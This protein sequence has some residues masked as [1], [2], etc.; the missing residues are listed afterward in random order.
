MTPIYFNGVLTYARQYDEVL[1]WAEVPYV[2]VRD[3]AP[4]SALA[5]DLTPIT[6]M[7][8]GDVSLINETINSEAI[9]LWAFYCIVIYAFFGAL[10]HFLKWSFWR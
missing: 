2:V 10:Y 6:I 1:G 7:Q 4:F 8:N 3:G 5:S 9:I